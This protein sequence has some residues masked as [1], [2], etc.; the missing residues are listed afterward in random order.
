[1]KAKIDD[2]RI[3]AV[4]LGE[5]DGRTSDSVQAWARTSAEAGAA[6]EET[7]RLAESLATELGAVG[8]R[9]SA[10]LTD[11]Q[12]AALTAYRPPRRRFPRVSVPALGLRQRPLAALGATMVALSF[13]CLASPAG[14][15][16]ITGLY[17]WRDQVKSSTGHQSATRSVYDGPS[18]S[19]WDVLRGGPSRGEVGGGGGADEYEAYAGVDGAREA[20]DVPG[21]VATAAPR[22]PVTGGVGGGEAPLP[23]AAPMVVKE[24][25]LSLEVPNVRVAVDRAGVIAAQ[26]GGFVVSSDA[27]RSDAPGETSNDYS[28]ASMTVRLPVDSFQ[29]AVNGLR[30]LASRVMTESS[31]GQE[32]TAEYVDMQSQ[33]ANLEATRARVRAFLDQARTVEEAL[34]VNAELTRLEGDINVLKGR[35]AQ[36]ADQ[37]AYSTINVEFHAPQADTEAPAK[38]DVAWNPRQTARRAMAAL[39]GI[40]KVLVDAGIWLA[41]VFLPIAVPFWLVAWAVHRRRGR[42]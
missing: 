4:A 32:V 10:G 26:H 23:G 22:A 11:A 30:A 1:M 29:A 39:V 35:M 15:A 27:Y 38:A 28:Y 42:P 20:V 34:Q 6:L 12:R 24:A 3:T 41:I 8:G 2:A 9:W 18:V 5:A 17:A 37:A 25:A 13:I 14:T 36:L 21:L 7:R 31:S 40:V 19:I 16:F 33:V